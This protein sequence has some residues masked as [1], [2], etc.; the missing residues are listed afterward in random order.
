M[1]WSSNIEAAWRRPLLSA[2]LVF[3]SYC[4]A[5]SAAIQFFVLPVLL[6]SL[7]AGHGL[8]A[9]GDY[10]GLHDIARR[11]ALRISQDGWSAW[12][13]MPEGQS[14]A[15]LA[16]IF[17]ALTVSE[18]WTLIPVNAALH[19]MGG[20]I[21]MRLVQFLG[22]DTISMLLCGALYVFLP[23]S[24]QW[25][26]QIQKDSYYFTGMLLFLLGCV[27]TVRAADGEVPFSGMF[28]GLALIALGMGFSCMVRLYALRF[29][30]LAALLFAVVVL[31]YL[32]SAFRSGRVPGVRVLFVCCTLLLVVL[33]VKLESTQGRLSVEMPFTRAESIAKYGADYDP[34][35]YKE[36]LPQARN[37]AETSAMMIWNKNKHLPAPIENAFLSLS[38]ARF[39]WIGSSYSSAGSMIDRDIQFDSA[40]DVV[41]YL[42]RA[43]QIG[44]F[45]PFPQHWLAEGKAPGGS[46]MRRMVGLE[47]TLLY[48]LLLIG[49]P[50]AVFQWGRRIEFWMIVTFLVPIIT[51]Y[52][53]IVPNLGTL[54]RLRYGFLTALAAIGLAAITL[55]YQRFKKNREQSALP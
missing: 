25:V 18:P 13:L 48:L 38:V 36:G 28:Y 4:V 17:Y 43:L 30:A 8:L 45:A 54:Y 3:F 10:P 6:P 16:S 50:L 47:M 33:S 7:H 49:L 41:L 51:L 34:P 12:E 46:L 55:S 1:N 5:A 11:M 26:S 2:F 39:G 23:S 9:G 37:L 40:A 20:V 19:A 44:L 35:E 21:V 31:P 24:M 15:G 42:P 32:V 14:P 22:A 53:Y 52:A 29:F 27:V